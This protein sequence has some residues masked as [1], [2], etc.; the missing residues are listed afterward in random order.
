MVDCG[1]YTCGAGKVCGGDNKCLDRNPEKSIVV[2]RNSSVPARKDAHKK[3]P[4]SP[5]TAASPRTSVALEPTKVTQSNAGR[6]QSDTTPS[7]LP[8]VATASVKDDIKPPPS[9]LDLPK[10]VSAPGPE[11]RIIPAAAEIAKVHEEI[12]KAEEKRV[13]LEQEIAQLQ[14]RMQALAL[15]KWQEHVEVYKDDTTAIAF[16]KGDVKLSCRI[17]DEKDS[18]KEKIHLDCERHSILIDA[19]PTSSTR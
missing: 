7:L 10:P 16:I 5:K 19:E 18:P 4:A 12:K 3:E 13:S 17:V 6:V 15:K 8:V 11:E 9:A 2:G 14:A 1:S